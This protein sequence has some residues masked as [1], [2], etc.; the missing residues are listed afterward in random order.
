MISALPIT[1]ESGSPA[2]I[3]LATII[4]SASTVVMLHREHAAGATESRLH[5][6]GDHDDALAIADPADPLDEL[7]RCG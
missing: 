7:G 2:A 3:D 6:V 5:L 4:R 1:P